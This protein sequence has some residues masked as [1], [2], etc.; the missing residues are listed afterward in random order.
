MLKIKSV[1]WHLSIAASA[2]AVVACGSERS[3]PPR[4]EDIGEVLAAVGESGCP[5]A[6]D[7][8]RFTATSS[9]FWGA[10]GTG[11]LTTDGGTCTGYIVDVTHQ[12]SVTYDYVGFIWNA[13]TNQTD[14]NNAEVLGQGL[15]RT[16][17]PTCPNFNNDGTTAYCGA[18]NGS[19][20]DFTLC[21]GQSGLP[22]KTSG[23]SGC[24]VSRTITLGRI[25]DGSQ[26]NY[27]NVWSGIYRY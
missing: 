15:T 16:G 4:D 26:W 18:W 5:A 25:W 7:D 10:V 14:C 8:A 9:G 24:T 12:T 19:S 1:L 20:C 27:Q 17:I 22:Q 3:E 11:N 13:I 6:V 2:L 23:A 21:P